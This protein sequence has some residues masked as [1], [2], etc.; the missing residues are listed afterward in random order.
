VS[1]HLQALI[2]HSGQ[3]PVFYHRQVALNVALARA[4]E[5]GHR[6]AVWW[7]GRHERGF[8]RWGVYRLRAKVGER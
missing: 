2:S 3:R 8:E 6:H 5:T 1:R 4:E 7:L